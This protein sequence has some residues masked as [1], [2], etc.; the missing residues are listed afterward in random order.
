MILLE[1][2]PNNL[3]KKV[4]KKSKIPVI[5]IGSSPYTDGQIL[6]M[7]DMLGIIKKNINL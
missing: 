6:V 5:G 7:H 2:V 1:C 3:A 4:T